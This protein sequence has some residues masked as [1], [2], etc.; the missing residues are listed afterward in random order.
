MKFPNMQKR[1]VI[2]MWSLNIFSL[3][4]CLIFINPDLPDIYMRISVD[5]IVMWF[6]L[7][8]SY[9]I[10]AIYF[11]NINLG[12]S[13]GEW[14]R[15]IADK[16]L[17]L[18]RKGDGLVVTDEEM[19]LPE[20]NPY[21]DKT[22]G[23]PDGTVRGTIALTILVLGTAMLLLRF[24]GAHPNDEATFSLMGEAFLMMVAFYFGTKGLELLRAKKE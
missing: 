4:T 5:L 16:E 10:W 17:A 24:S 1:I 18:K 22:F 3:G 23:L 15:M 8:F 20:D 12:Y 21:K 14:E 6:A 9:Y 11:Y 7:M 13:D 19:S 2:A